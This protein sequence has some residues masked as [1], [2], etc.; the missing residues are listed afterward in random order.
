MGEIKAIMLDGTTIQRASLHNF[1]KIRRKGTRLNEM[2][3]ILKAEGKGITTG[4]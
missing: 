2:V 1:Y 4:S 3:V